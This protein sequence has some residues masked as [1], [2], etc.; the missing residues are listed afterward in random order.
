M[1]IKAN[2]KNGL[3]LVETLFSVAII[4][5]AF[6]FLLGTFVTGKMSIQRVK[7][8]MEARN[9]LRAKMEELKNTTYKNI[10]SK[11]STIVTIGPGLDLIKGT[12]DD[13]IGKQIIDVTDR[14][15]YKEITITLSWEE[16]GWGGAK[17]VSETL[18]SYIYMWGIYE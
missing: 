6:C 14:N 9:F 10:V 2:A 8:R 15:G 5:L 16:I 1:S 3:T 12:D 17:G 13:L 4:I 7:H 18:T 11:E